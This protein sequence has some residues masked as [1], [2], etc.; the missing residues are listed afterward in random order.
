MDP[1]MTSL[2]ML[3]Y[4]NTCIRQWRIE[5]DNSKRNWDTESQNVAE[6][7]VD[8]FQSVRMSFF[9]ELLPPEEIIENEGE[10]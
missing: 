3:E 5:R 4:L 8:A 2:E 10:E 1:K 6:C 7:Y 9:G